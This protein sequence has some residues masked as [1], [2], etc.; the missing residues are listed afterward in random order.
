MTFLHDSIKFS[1]ITMRCG[2]IAITVYSGLKC[3]GSVISFSFIT[4][5]NAEGYT[6]IK[7]I[8]VIPKNSMKRPEQSVGPFL[9]NS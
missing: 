1:I 5:R 6:W 3:I 8:C 9:S 4:Q 7:D 2:S